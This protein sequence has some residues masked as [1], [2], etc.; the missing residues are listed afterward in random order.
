[1]SS[2]GINDMANPQA[3]L[4]AYFREK[5]SYWAEIYQR[6]GIKEA[7]H[8]ERLH[9]A[10]AMVDTLR[11]PPEAR[12]LDVGCGDGYAT[13][14]LASRRLMVDAVDPLQVMVH[15]M[16]NRAI[17]A[18]SQSRVATRIG[19]VHAL[20]FPDNTCGLRDG[21]ELHRIQ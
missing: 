15:T 17:A 3:V 2:P 19:D 1:M 12:V 21:I 8:Q 16:R 14:A 11:L 13:V 20:P 6:E 18:G 9:A 7:I 10:L 5:A 4:N